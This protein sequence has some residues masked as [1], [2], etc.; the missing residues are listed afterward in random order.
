MASQENI[1]NSLKPL[2]AL[3]TR[4]LIQKCKVQL[5]IDLFITCGY[6]NIEE[7]NRLYAQ[8]RSVPGN[9]VTNAKGG[10]SFHQYRVAIDVCPIIAGKLDWNY[11]FS[12]IAKIA[13]TEEFE[14][15]D[16]GY[17]DLPHFEYRAGYSLEAFQNGRIDEDKFADKGALLALIQKLKAQLS[18]LLSRKK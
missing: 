16:R 4:N 6:R 15:G 11:D 2:V 10:Q 3:K 7:Q 1:I 9:I 17:V 12:K 14:W 8:G 13:L 18:L 5:G